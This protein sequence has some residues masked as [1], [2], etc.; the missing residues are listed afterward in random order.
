M[1][2]AEAAQPEYPFPFYV[3]FIL[4]NEFCERYANTGLRAILTIFL[5]SFVGFD[6]D[7]STILYHLFEVMAYMFSLLGA[8]LADGYWGKFNTI[9]RLSVVY[10]IGMIVIAIAAIPFD[11]GSST[12]RTP[13]AILVCS[14]LVIA[15]VG[16][17]GI[18]P[19]VSSFGGDQFASD[20]VKGTSTFFDLFY[21]AINAGS[22]ISLFVSP[23]L[24]TTTCGSLGTDTSCFFI[25]FAIPAVLFIIAIFLFLFG[26][27]YYVK[28][29][30]SGTNIF[31]DTLA[32][33][34]YGMW[35]K[36][37]K[38]SPVQ[39]NWLYGAYG[40]K[41]TWIIRDTTYLVR[42]LVMFAPITIFWAAF[43]QQGSRWTLQAI[44]MNGYIGSAHI[45]PDQAQIL[46]P[47][48]ILTFI[49]IFNWLYKAIDKCLG[50]TLFTQL[51]KINIGM[52]FA[53]VAYFVAALIQSKIDVNLTV[54]PAIESQISLKVINARNDHVKG[55]FMAQNQDLVPESMAGVIYD[56]PIGGYTYNLESSCEE[57]NTSSDCIKQVSTGE[58]IA[59]TVKD[60]FDSAT[61]TT[62]TEY[63]FEYNNADFGKE[64]K[65]D[66][67]ITEGRQVWTT[68]LFDNDNSLTF[69]FWAEKDTDGKAHMVT[70]S[71]L[72]INVN[73]TFT[74]NEGSTCSKQ[75]E[76]IAN[77][78]VCDQK[79]FDELA[80]SYASDEEQEEGEKIPCVQ[81]SVLEKD[82]Y[83][84]TLLRGNYTIDVIDLATEKVIKTESN[85]EIGTGAGYTLMILGDGT[86]EGT[87]FYMQQDIN[88]NDVSLLYII[89]QFFIIT[90]AE[91]LISI[92]GLEFAYTQAPVTLK[93]VLAAWWLLTVSVGNIVVIIVAEGQF[94]DSQVGEY[95]L[96]A[97]LIIASNIIFM[98]LS[99]FYYEYVAIDE[100]DNFEYPAEVTGQ[101]NQAVKEENDGDDL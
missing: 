1:G 61:D 40:K 96:F 22:L 50:F 72:P 81:G 32:C 56:L 42:V 24:R 20:D 35:N 87:E 31:I 17:G 69:A 37:P 3:T 49:P 59:E 11:D 10:A 36:I 75:A 23:I 74:C 15:A 14:G 2:D 45:L 62:D 21:W 57:G 89:P 86:A 101:Q 66:F 77:L 26:N 68:A 64:F 91:V 18:K 16:T 13:N 63:Y 7:I 6:K 95:I 39:D 60:T 8:A 51:R 48:L 38:D 33:I 46:N 41:D 82:E 29:P 71:N 27:R 70:V 55:Q 85:V 43:D 19:C 58:I 94:M 34:W 12:F 53:A 4:G 25:A 67:H 65:A 100:F 52:V 90:V 98:L 9:L 79:Y 84:L 76:T 47:V 97:G 99:I 30:A 44:N 28:K 73:V 93:S 83:R 92:T 80:A 5:F 78:E 54:R 88:A